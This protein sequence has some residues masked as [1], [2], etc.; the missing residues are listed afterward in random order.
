ME[1][2]TSKMIAV[3]VDGSKNALHSVDYIK[4]LYESGHR[5][6]LSLL[7]ILPALPPILVEE[8]KKNRQ[9]AAQL[10]KIEKNNIELAEHILHEAKTRLITKGCSDKSIH[11]TF[12]NKEVGVARDICTWV[13]E[14]KAD[15]VL[16]TTR[17]KS[18]LEALFMGEV[19]NKVLELCRGC[20]IWMIKGSV[21]AKN[22]LIA[23]DCSE[24]TLRAVDHAGFMLSATTCKIH[25]FHSKRNLNRFIPKEI[26]EGASELE[27]LWQQTAEEEITPY[28]KKAHQ[29]LIDA[30]VDAALISARV[31]D[32]SRRPAKDILREAKRHECGTIVMGRRGVSNEAEFTMGSITRKVIEDCTDMAVWIVP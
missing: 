23:L 2:E 8:S 6:N 20:P 31:A 13:H 15:T 7:Y 4:L 14:K 30:G 29:T 24:N 18:R 12:R 21:K 32:G 10:K 19:S 9:T 28:M 25:F 17:G 16:M 22:I 5:I 26:F 1:T 3:P 11:T 27:E